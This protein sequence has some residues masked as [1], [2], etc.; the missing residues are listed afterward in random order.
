MICAEL[1]FLEAQLD[2]LITALERNDLQEDEKRK[3][4]GEYTG[5]AH[6]IKDHQLAGHSGKPCYEE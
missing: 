6:L 2:E 5:V 3:L 4:E 1:E